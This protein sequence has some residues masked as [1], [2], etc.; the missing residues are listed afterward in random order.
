ML[1]LFLDVSSLLRVSQDYQRLEGVTKRISCSMKENSY[2][3]LKITLALPIPP[4]K[5]SYAG[6]YPRS[7]PNEKGFRKLLHGGEEAHPKLK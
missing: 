6:I 4:L 1:T 2:S 3:M 5:I 7:I